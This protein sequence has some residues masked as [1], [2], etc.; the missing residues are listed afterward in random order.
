MSAPI[1]IGSSPSSGSTLLWSRLTRLPGIA[2][3]G[4][5]AVLDRAAL[6]DTPAAAL[7][8]SVLTAVPKPF[9][10]GTPKAFYRSPQWGIE[11]DEV[12]ELAAGSGTWHELLQ[13]F[14]GAAVERQAARR[15]LEKTPGNVFAFRRTLEAFPDALLVQIV[16]DGRDV[17]QSQLDRGAPP[18]RAVSRWFT[19]VLAGREHGGLTLRYEELA[20]DPEQV[21][22]RLCGF[23]G[24]PFDADVLSPAGEE[25]ALP[26]W[27]ARPGEAI[28][29]AAVG[30]WRDGGAADTILAHLAALRLSPAGE[31]QLGDRSGIGA[32]DLLRELGYDEPTEPRALRPDELDAATAEAAE[33]AAAQEAR[34][35]RVV[36]PVPTTLVT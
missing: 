1:V 6:F 11:H 7:R 20:A 10:T 33:Y 2:S 13:R 22:R 15:W 17:V 18:F 30:R 29:T 21:V 26:S 3:G 36:Y 16:R 27:T 32:L 9:V 4:E 24:E 31:E 34:H 5:L 28:T 8:D 25:G 35:G 14:F 12:R 23:V 19:A